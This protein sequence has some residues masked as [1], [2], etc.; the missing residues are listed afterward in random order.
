GPLDE[1]PYS[2]PFF[3]YWTAQKFS[4]SKVE[5]VISPSGKPRGT[6]ITTSEKSFWM[7]TGAGHS[8]S[9]PYS[10]AVSSTPSGQDAK[11]ASQPHT[12]STGSDVKSRPR[13]VYELRRQLERMRANEISVGM[14]VRQR[15]DWR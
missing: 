6:K 8:T 9:T 12:K 11:A 2:T 15:P 3:P 14:Q 7:P 1:S 5:S 13:D 4:S 10:V